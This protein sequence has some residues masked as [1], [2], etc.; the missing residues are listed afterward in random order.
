[1]PKPKKKPVKKKTLKKKT[2]K[3]TASKKRLPLKDLKIDQI[4]LKTR[5]VFIYGDINEKMSVEVTKQ[6]IALSLISSEPIYIRINSRG[7]SVMDGLSIID[8]I[9][10]LGCPVVTMISGKAFS[11][12]GIISVVGDVRVMTKNSI[13]L[14]HPISS[15]QGNDYIQ[16]LRDRMVFLDMLEESGDE[17]LKKYT[18]LKPEDIVKMKHGELWLTA[19]D[20]LKNG[21]VDKIV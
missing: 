12:G 1:M 19:Q 5:C 3:K 6:L 7:G 15:G 21:I 9:K 14:G 8:T 4:L 2:T 17:I 13:W 18:K 10:S 16:F 11:M 20:C